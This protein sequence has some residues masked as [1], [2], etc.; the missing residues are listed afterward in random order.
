MQAA[1]QK[2]VDIG[3]G[4]PDPEEDG[5]L[6]IDLR[7]P[8]TAS[9]ELVGNLKQIQKEMVRQWPALWCTLSSDGLSGCAQEECGRQMTAILVAMEDCYGNSSH[10]VLA[11]RSKE[12]AWLSNLAW[13]LR[14][15]G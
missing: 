15:A 5:R 12:E 14:A 11:K 9:D 1:Q 10:N 6:L 2:A 4:Y 7:A 3:A 13:W 8:A